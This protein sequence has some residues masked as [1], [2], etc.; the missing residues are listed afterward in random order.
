VPQIFAPVADVDVGTWTL[1][2]AATAREC[3]ND[4]YNSPNDNT[5]Y[6]NPAEDEVP[7]TTLK[8]ALLYADAGHP[9]VDPATGEGHILH[10]RA[11]SKLLNADPP[12]ELEVAL[13]EFT[14]GI[15]VFRAT[16]GPVIVT[17]ST[18]YANYSYLLTPTEADTITDYAHL[19]IW[20][21]SLGID[22]GE[23]IFVRLTQ[24][25]MEIPDPFGTRLALT[26]VGT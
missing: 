21:D 14:G 16:S 10:W 7:S 9:I 18:D 22:A 8:V 26:G 17:R 12:E 13:Y 25:W 19:H 1:N 2:G 4:Q 15:Y 20:V 3:L 6:V 5:D 23:V 11:W 24:V